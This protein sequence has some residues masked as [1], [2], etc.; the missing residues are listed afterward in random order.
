MWKH[1]QI[2]CEWEFLSRSYFKVS[3]FKGQENF[4]LSKACTLI[5]LPS[6][7]LFLK[8]FF[9]SV[10]DLTHIPLFKITPYHLQVISRTQNLYENSLNSRKAPQHRTYKVNK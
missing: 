2:S 4:N 5:L 3:V 7:Q 1:R 9:C 10:S 8:Y 6:P